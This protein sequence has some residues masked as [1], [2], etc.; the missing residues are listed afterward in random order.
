MTTYTEGWYLSLVDDNDGLIHHR[1]LRKLIVKGWNKRYNVF[2]LYEVM[3]KHIE[4]N[5]DKQIVVFKTL[6]VLNNYI[7]K[8]PFETFSTNLD[9]QT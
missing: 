2:K 5:I 9:Q 3:N 4:K 8:G 1:Y 6:I 7:R